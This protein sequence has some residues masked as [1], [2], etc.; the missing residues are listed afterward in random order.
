M[1]FVDMADVVGE[2]IQ[3]RPYVKILN[4]PTLKMYEVT[5]G[6]FRERWEA[7]AQVE[8]WLCVV[9]LKVTDLRPSQ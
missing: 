6:V 5:P 3:E 9:E 4:R 7:L 8:D 1:T 2:V